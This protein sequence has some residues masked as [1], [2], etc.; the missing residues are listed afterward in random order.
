M[1]NENQGIKMRDP[2]ADT[3]GIKYVKGY[4]LRLLCFVNRLLMDFEKGKLRVTLGRKVTD[5]LSKRGGQNC[6]KKAP[7]FKKP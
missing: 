3:L 2:F 7:N 5:S 6:Q 1:I 4:G